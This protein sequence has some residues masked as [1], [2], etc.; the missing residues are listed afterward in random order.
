MSSIEFIADCT[1]QEQTIV[2]TLS[3]T[4]WTVLAT[5]LAVPDWAS[6][7]IITAPNGLTR[8]RLNGN[9][10]A[11]APDGTISAG[12]TMAANEVRVLG[13]RSGRS[14]TLGLSTAVSSGTVR[15]EWLP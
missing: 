3:A 14:R 12:A 7:A 8:Y 9:P 13:L 11:G 5:P 2:A 6:R 1:G 4:A 10:A 15:V